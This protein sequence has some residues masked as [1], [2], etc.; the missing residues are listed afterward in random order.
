M[1]EEIGPVQNCQNPPWDTPNW[2][3]LSFQCR[4]EWKDLEETSEPS[5]RFCKACHENVHLVTNK[6]EFES[7]ASLKHCVSVKTEENEFR[8]TGAPQ[9]FS[10]KEIS[11]E[12]PKTHEQPRRGHSPTQLQQQKKLTPNSILKESDINLAEP[13]AA[14]LKA[15]YDVAFLVPTEN[16]MRKS[17]MDAHD[18]VR[19][20]LKRNE[21]HDYKEQ[22]QGPSRKVKIK[23]QFVT[24]NGI[25]EKKVSLYRPKTKDGDP[26]IWIYGLKELAQAY[27]LIALIYSDGQLFIVNCSKEE[28]LEIAL[29]GAIPKPAQALSAVAFELLQKLRSISNRGFIPSIRQGDTG[30]GMT[31]ENLLGIAAN[32]SKSPDYKGIELKASRIS[33][34]GSVRNKSQLF[35]KTPSWKLSPMETAERLVATRGYIDGDGIQALRHTISGNKPNSRGLYLD[36][37][38]ANDYLRQMFTDVA[39]RDFNPEH[40]MTWVFDDLR[41]ALK[42][43]HRETFWVKAFHNN[44]RTDEQFHYATVEHTKDPYIEK[45]ETLFETG[46]V[47]MDYTLHLKPSGKARD[48][49]YLFKLKPNCFEA[50]FPKPAEYDLTA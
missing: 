1:S 19:A 15:G 36:V 3:K 20:F 16:A 30:V 39:V 47:T 32:P 7:A 46:I 10:G 14:I 50:L 43:K 29:S 2:A 44:D 49:G 11:Q 13:S 22:Q 31:L 6:E 42:K 33:N 37:D 40:D 26:R 18:S 21:L 8:L 23:A 5:K 25:R 35:S 27:N 45:L 4:M 12:E 34:R 38:Y 24:T 17:I 28:D 41:K 9:I 48:H